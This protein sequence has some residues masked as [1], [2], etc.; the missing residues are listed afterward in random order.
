MPFITAKDLNKKLM[1]LRTTYVRERTKIKDS[2]KSGA[3]TQ[4]IYKPTWLHFDQLIFLD[5]YIASRKTKSN[6]QVCSFH[7]HIECHEVSHL[8]IMQNKFI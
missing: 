2:Q 4:E 5:D 3:G 7:F 1:N 6:L 8:V